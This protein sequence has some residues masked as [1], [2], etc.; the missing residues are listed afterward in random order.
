[1][2]R[3]FTLIELLVVIS[4]IA[5]LIAILLPALS[6]A[7][8]SARASQCL[9]QLRQVGIAVTTYSVDYKQKFPPNRF[10]TGYWF[11][12]RHAAQYFP[13][14][15]P[16]S[17][18]TGGILACP[19]DEGAVRN[20]CLNMWASPVGFNG[21]SGKIGVIGELFNA[22]VI[23]ASDMIL[24][25]EGLAK[26]GSS[27]SHIAGAGFGELGATPG[28]RFTGNVGNTS[29]SRWGGVT[30]PTQINWTLHG[31]ND[32]I[33]AAAGQTHFAYADGHV[34][35]NQQSELV[36]NAGASTLEALWSPLDPELV[37]P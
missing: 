15:T 7:R 10:S 19:N 35:V 25:G 4:I 31:S 3:A 37:I 24:A 18:V 36:D 11:D 29:G 13:N 12:E 27:G 1:M 21:D 32:D 34:E 5:L 6:S 33:E 22:D 28:L 26:W 2:R 23:N 14:E 30:L 16:G 17:S 20:Y 9:S 8:G